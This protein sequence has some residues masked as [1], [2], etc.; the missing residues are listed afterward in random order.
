MSTTET[1]YRAFQHP[2]YQTGWQVRD[3]AGAV[4]SFDHWPEADAWAEQ[5]G[6]TDDK[7][8]PFLPFAERFVGAILEQPEYRSKGR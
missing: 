2:G 7:P 1:H 4:H 3:S 5:N 6:P 8:N